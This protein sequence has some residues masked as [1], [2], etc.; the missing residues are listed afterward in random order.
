MEIIRTWLRF[1]PEFLRPST[2]VNKII[3]RATT[4]LV[5]SGPFKGM[6]WETNAMPFSQLGYLL[7]TFERELHSLIED[8]INRNFDRI[9]NIGGGFGYYAVGLARRNVRAQV[10]VFEIQDN[11]RVFIRQLA[12]RNRVESRISIQGGCD[13]ERLRLACA[14]AGRTLI[15]IDVEGA[16]EFLLDPAAIPRL[17]TCDILV[18]L[19]EFINPEIPS[20]LRSRFQK[21]HSVHEN[22]SRPR[23]LADFPFPAL[24]N[25]YYFLSRHFKYSMNERR[26]GSMRWWYLKPHQENQ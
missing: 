16:E 9:I 14:P 21:S 8:L 1:V 2:V 10:M 4:G 3:V 5:A 26:P 24:A 19:H 7:G 11:L 18:E 25:K 13:V 15:V 23:A 12:A 20:L 17:L 6:A 22:V